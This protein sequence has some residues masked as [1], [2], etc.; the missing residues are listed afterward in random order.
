MRWIAILMMTSVAAM[1][2]DKAPGWLQELSSRAI[3]EYED[4]VSAVEL[5]R[6]RTVTVEPNGRITTRT[7]GA[8]KVLEP[9]G[10]NRAY[11]SVPYREGSSKVVELNG[12]LIHPSGEVREFK[13]KDIV[14]ASIADF[15]L[16]SESRMRLVSAASQA[17][18][19]A[20]F[21]YEAV[22]EERSIFTQVTHPFQGDLPVLTSRFRLEL[23]AGWTMEP[24]MLNH[25]E[26]AAQQSGS[27]YLWQL[28]RLPP[29][30]DEP[31]RGTLTS[32]VPRVAISYFPSEAGDA[33]PTFHD[34][35]DV[36]RWQYSLY[37]PQMGADDA[38][39]AKSG[40]LAAGAG[41]DLEKIRAVGKYVQGIRYVA[42]SIGLDSGGGYTPHAAARILAS[43]Y[44]DCKDKV[45]LVRALLAEAG[46]RSYPVAVYSGDNRFVRQ[47][48][49][50]PH[51]FNHVIVAVPVAADVEAPAVMETERFGR[52][53]FFDP[54]DEYTPVGE[55]PDHLQGGYSLIIAAD[56]GELVKA[57]AVP[58]SGSRLT[59]T[60]T[61][62]IDPTGAVAVELS[63]FCTGASASYNRGLHR[64]MTSAEYRKIIERWITASAP[65]AAVDTIEAGEAQDNGF[66]VAVAFKADRYGQLMGNRLL[67]FRPAMVARRGATSFPDPER[68]YPV[69]LDAHAYAETATIATPAGFVV[70]ERPEP[71]VLEAEFARYHGEVEE[72]EGQLV[73]HRELEVE[74]AEIP[75]ERYE[76]VRTF[77]GRITAFEE[78]PVVL[79]K[80]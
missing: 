63:E 41:T 23:P 2:A 48:W 60:V 12:W 19:G 40:E 21:G 45:T 24:T 66:S 1:A 27:S 32:L 11:I 17:D 79:L 53:L 42:I 34:W 43:G 75:P 71:L 16:Y 68:K 10:R 37:E 58:P 6:E 52:L 50:S 76:E 73:L 20:V 38:L 4:H 29:I 18:P 72:L 46:I 36:G 77:F 39:R 57:P 44:G 9:G 5:L 26:V 55:L 3:P 31:S 56:G 78:S 59:R 14:D 65:G 13:K 25:G 62:Q 67:M 33:G 35:D 80:K 69:E 8:L 30:V 51:Q 7:R 54:T 49:P 70:D 28:T 22:E 15:E 74:S 61:A 64:R 47:E